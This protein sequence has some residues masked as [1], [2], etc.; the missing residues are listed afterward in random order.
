MPCSR[1]RSMRAAARVDEKLLIA[2]ADGEADVALYL[3]QELLDR[4]AQHDPLTRL[5]ARESRRLLVGARRRESLHVLRVERRARQVRVAV[6]ARAASRGRQIRDDGQAAA[7]ADGPRAERLA[8]L[9]VRFADAGRRARRRRTRALSTREP[10]RREVLLAA[11]AVPPWTRRLC[12]ASCGA[13]TACRKPRSSPTST[14]TSL[15]HRK[16]ETPGPARSL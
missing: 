4:L 8:R 15:R 12:R 2:E 1:A 13:S 11:C 14:P 10:L 7:R 3:E 6:R 5:D 9:V 16:P